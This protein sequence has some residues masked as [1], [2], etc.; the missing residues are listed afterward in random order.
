MNNTHSSRY[1]AL[2]VP[3]SVYELFGRLAIILLPYML[4]C[5][6]RCVQSRGVKTVG[7][8]RKP[9]AKASSRITPRAAALDGPYIQAPGSGVLGQRN[10]PDSPAV[11]AKIAEEY[12]AMSRI[13]PFSS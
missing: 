13:H 2:H 5:A 8:Y 4:R 9:K 6:V 7:Y 11:V 3:R 10:Q 1:K 12:E